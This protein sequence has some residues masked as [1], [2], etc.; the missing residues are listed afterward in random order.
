MGD[1]SVQLRLCQFEGILQ[2]AEAIRGYGNS[3]FAVRGYRFEELIVNVCSIT[4]D[5]S[6][7]SHTYKGT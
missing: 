3:L 5:I 6:L 7:Y 4:V 1:S 2:S